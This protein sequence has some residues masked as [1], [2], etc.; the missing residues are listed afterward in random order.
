MEVPFADDFVIAPPE[1][2]FRYHAWHRLVGNALTERPILASEFRSFL[3]YAPEWLPENWPDAPKG[4]V[5][6]IQDLGAQDDLTTSLPFQVRQAFQGWKNYF[7][8]GNAI[9]ALVVSK[10]ELEEFLS[11]FPGYARNN[12]RNIVGVEYLSYTLTPGGGNDDPVPATEIPG[13]L[14][15]AL[16]NYLAAVKG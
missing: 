1:V 6:V 2:L 5:E 13:F 9:N 14:R 7:M 10:R 4:Y 16:Y 8:E 3:Q 11:L 15:V 12:W